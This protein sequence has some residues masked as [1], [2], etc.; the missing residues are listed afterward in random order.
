MRGWLSSPT[1]PVARRVSIVALAIGWLALGA[2]GAFLG[3]YRPASDEDGFRV[4]LLLIAVMRATLAVA[5]PALAAGVA[6]GILAS[7][8]RPRPW[9]VAFITLSAL[10][11]ALLLAVAVR[12][13]LGG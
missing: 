1:A 7:R 9:H 6:A 5:I 2:F 3:L 4:V 12:D 10:A 11:L 13:A 8:R